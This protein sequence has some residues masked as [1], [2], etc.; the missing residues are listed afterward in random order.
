LPLTAEVVERNLAGAIHAGLYPLLPGDVCQ[1]LACDFDGPGWVLDVLALSNVDRLTPESAKTIAAGFSE[2]AAGPDAATYHRARTYR[3]APKPPAEIKARTGAML[4]VDPIGVPPALVAALKHLASLHNP[5][6]YEKERLRFST[7]NTPRFIR[8]YRENLDQLLLP[9]GLRDK[10]EKIVAA[11]APSIW[12]SMRPAIELR[13][14]VITSKR[15]SAASS[16]TP[17]GRVPFATT[18]LPLPRVAETRSCSRAGPN[19]SATL[20]RTWLNAGWTRSFFTAVSARRLAR[21]SLTDSL[22]PTPG[23]SWS[24]PRV[25]SGKASI[26]RPSTRSSSPS[27]SG[28]RAM[29]VQYVGRVLRPTATKTRVEVHDYVDVN[30]PPLARMHDERR[31]AYAALGFDIPRTGTRR[32][33]T[34]R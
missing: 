26:V 25:C 28:S 6:F 8:C 13:R 20:S 16:K 27:R 23:S 22:D 5:E 33:G 30:V 32:S 12:S 3:T 7:W 17:S 31:T 1:V 15:S 2:L 34:K 10:A 24:P 21:P 19:T 11:S 18:S 9:R 14:T 29:W 4:A